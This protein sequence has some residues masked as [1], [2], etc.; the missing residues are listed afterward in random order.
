MCVL[1]LDCLSDSE[2]L[3]NRYMNF[4]TLENSRQVLPNYE[5]TNEIE[6][7]TPTA[8]KLLSKTSYSDVSSP[9]PPLPSFLFSPVVLVVLSV[10]L[11]QLGKRN[12]Y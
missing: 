8:N 12:L 10:Y 4:F 11:K 7:H 1:R 9:P 2:G 5:V 3:K 6:C